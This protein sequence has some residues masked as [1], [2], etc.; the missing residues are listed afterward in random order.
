M[1]FFGPRSLTSFGM[2]YFAL[3]MTV[4]PVLRMTVLPVILGAIFF[5]I[6][7]A[8]KDLHAKIP[9]SEVQ[10]TKKDNT[11]LRGNLQEILNKLLPI[12]SSIDLSNLTATGTELNALDGINTST[13]TAANLNTLTSGSSSDAVAL[14]THTTG[15][16][17]DNAQLLDSID[18]TS[19]LRSDTSDSFSSGTLTIDSG[20]TLNVA[21]TFQIGGTTVS[22]TAAELNKLSGTS[23]NVTA[24]NLDTLT[25]AGETTL[26]SHAGGSTTLDDGYNNDT[27]GD[28]QITVD[29]RDISFDL[30]DSTN[31][32]KVSIDN[33]TIGT[34][35][36]G[37][38]ITVS[39]VGGTFVDA[40]DASHASIDNALNVGDNDI[41]GTT[42]TITFTDFT[43][44]ADGNTA[45]LTDTAGSTAML[46]LTHSATSGTQNY[47]ILIS[48]GTGGTMTD[49][50]DV[51]DAEI[52]N[53]LN[54][55]DNDIEGTTAT[56]T[57]TDFTVGADGNTA[58]L[59]DTAGS[60][61][62]VALSHAAT[63]GTQTDGISIAIGTGATMTDALDVSDDDI[64]NALNIGANDFEGTTATITF[65][66]FTVGADG[67]ISIL[68]DTAGATAMLALTHAATSGTQTDGIS[69]DIG[70]GGAITDALDVSDD[71]IDNALNI[72]AND[73]EG[74][75][76]TITFTDFTVGSDG[77]TAILTDTAGSTA[78]VAL[79]HAA[80]TGTQTDG[81]SIAIG[82]GATMTDALDV[83]D[84]DIDN[85]LNIGA[86]DFEGTT[87]TITFT[88]FTVGSDGNIAILSD[89]AGATPMLNLAHSATS[90]TQSTGLYMISSGATVT[91]GLDVSDPDIDNAI[92]LGSNELDGAFGGTIEFTDFTVDSDGNTAILTDTAGSTAMINLDM[93]ATTG[94]PRIGF[95]ILISGAVLTDAIDVSDDDIVNAL[96]IGA[97][98]I[99]GTTGVIDFTDFDVDADGDVKVNF[100]DTVTTNGVCHSGADID[101]GTDNKRDLV[102]CSAAPGDLAEWYEAVGLLSAGEIVVTTPQF[103]S[104]NAAERDEK[105]GAIVTGPRREISKLTKSL[106]PYQS[107]M[108]GVVSTTPWQTMGSAVKQQGKN[109]YPVALIGR[110]PTKV[111][112]QNG[113]IFPGDRIT[114]SAIPGIGMKATK[115]GPAIGIAL[116]SFSGSGIGTIM[117]YA[118]NHSFIPEKSQKGL[119]KLSD[120]KVSEALAL[121]SEPDNLR[122]LK[123]TL[124]L[125]TGSPQRALLEEVLKIPPTKLQKLIYL[126]Q[127]ILKKIDHPG[128]TFAQVN[129]LT[130]ENIWKILEKVWIMEESLVVEGDIVQILT[131]AEGQKRV[132]FARAETR[133]YLYEYGEG[134]WVNGFARVQLDPRFSELIDVLPEFPIQAK[135]T[136]TSRIISGSL[137]ITER[138]KDYFIVEDIKNGKRSNTQGTFMWEVSALQRNSPTQHYLPDEATY[139]QSFLDQ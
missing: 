36:D 103:F 37:L 7:S 126:S 28:A 16:T 110:V 136:P 60:T 24:A 12:D 1:R 51:S 99:E 56:I 17:A 91:D 131:D 97:N 118:M 44:G 117:M 55:G 83:S 72:G 9:A 57:F 19:F 132:T 113:Q 3:R 14:H 26:H 43:V 86:N 15:V 128:L 106:M 6:L 125:Y 29:A 73:F 138:G 2:T 33:T 130:E 71:D 69:I 124:Q 101:A 116:S 90:G 120:P 94:T 10:V 66:D 93:I 100:T 114:S 38:E 13:V 64:D 40:I 81:I 50:I 105:T 104:Y 22:S 112:A 139:L 11:G 23:S 49:A 122:N 32:Y 27:S 88:D 85:A 78:M 65:T 68:T 46:A 109:I 70:T 53:A 4:L 21:G 52:D 61:A 41:E 45:I 5:V 63:T 8:A 108:I 92:N 39:G 127:K 119:G 87:A 133:P 80:T 25:G 121:L 129:G 42:A 76:A 107:N 74:T 54:V 82:T 111:T 137:V 62:M 47:G 58:I 102:V 75:T 67:N 34:I 84:D 123:T 96:N 30:N 95:N 18:S 59:T 20:T 135:V 48:Q 79:S 89:T 35:A 134:F 115:P 98:E 77:N 31:D